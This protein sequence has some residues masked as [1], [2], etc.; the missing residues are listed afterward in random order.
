MEWNV[1]KRSG[2]S[3]GASKS[4][5]YDAYISDDLLSKNSGKDKVDERET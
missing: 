2:M 3:E 1:N 5:P 4:H